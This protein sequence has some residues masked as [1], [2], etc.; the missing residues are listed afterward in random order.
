MLLPPAH[1]S[2]PFCYY[3]SVL[4]PGHGKCLSAHLCARLAAHFQLSLYT[5]AK[6]SVKGLN[7]F[8]P[9]FAFWECSDLLRWL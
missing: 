9:I 7:L 8:M 5:V 3:G 2:S 6:G 1:F 4:E